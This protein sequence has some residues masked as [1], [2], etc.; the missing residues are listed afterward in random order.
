METMNLLD[1][2]IKYFNVIVFVLCIL[3][4][5]ISFFASWVAWR[6]LH[7]RRNIIR[8]IVAAYNI[9]EDTVEKGRTPLGELRLDPAIVETVFNSL[10]E[11]LNSIYGEVT[12]KPMPPREERSHGSGKIPGLSAVSRV[13]MR[14]DT[15]ERL[16]VDRAVPTLI[17]E[18][19]EHHH[20]VS[21]P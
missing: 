15:G 1:F 16:N 4:G 14:K 20:T 19:R 3:F 12:G 7:K 2:T 9:A 18:D 8:S 17:P 21:H 11:V 13:L 5:M 6:E 10:Q